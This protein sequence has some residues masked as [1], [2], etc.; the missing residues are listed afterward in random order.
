M[1]FILSLQNMSSCTQKVIKQP[2]HRWFKVCVEDM[3]VSAGTESIRPLTVSRVLRGLGLCEQVAPRERQLSCPSVCF[4]R[5]SCHQQSLSPPRVLA[6]GCALCYHMKSGLHCVNSPCPC[7]CTLRTHRSSGGVFPSLAF[8]S[9][10]K[11]RIMG[12]NP[13]TCTHKHSG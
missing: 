5:P 12:M 13:V 4:V 2:R 3:T 8:S 10:Y 11:R 9:A 7:S 6:F 1:E